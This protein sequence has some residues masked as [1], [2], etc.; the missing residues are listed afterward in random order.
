MVHLDC[1]DVQFVA[2]ANPP[3]SAH[4]RSF[5]D[6]GINPRSADAIVQKSFFQYRLMYLGTSHHH[7]P[8]APPVRAICMPPR[9]ARSRCR[10]TRATT[11]R[12]G[13][14]SIAPGGPRAE[15]ARQKPSVV[16]IAAP[17]SSSGRL[18]T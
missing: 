17:P 7:V 11:S 18:P 5:R 8:V 14:P 13:A 6:V 4:P 1:G 16:T 3:L 10:P 15:L 9:A 12:T 2:S